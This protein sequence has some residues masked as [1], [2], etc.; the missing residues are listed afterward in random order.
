MDKYRSR[1]ENSV[2]RISL[3]LKILY[4]I[5]FINCSVTLLMI[6]MW[7]T[8]YLGGQCKKDD[9]Q[10]GPEVRITANSHTNLTEDKSEYTMRKRRSYTANVPSSCAVFIRDCKDTIQDSFLLKGQKGDRGYTGVPGVTGSTGQKGSKGDTGA[11]GPIGP[12]GRRGEVGLPGLRGSPGERG[13]PGEP[14]IPGEPGLPGPKGDKG[15]QG[16][17]GFPG[18]DGPA[19]LIG[20]KGAPG[21]RGPPGPYGPVGPTGPP[22]PIGYKGDKGYRGL[23][24]YTGHKGDKGEVGPKGDQGYGYPGVTGPRGPKGDKGECQASS[25][26]MENLKMERDATNRPVRTPQRDKFVETSYGRNVK[27]DTNSDKK[28]SWWAFSM[29]II[30]AIC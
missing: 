23:I 9:F 1:E 15:K 8:S 26:K 16:L 19:G 29:I 10:D 3:H 21:E 28:I 20:E 4:G 18:D 7:Y 22:G 11:I 14:G 2:N 5:L 24:G 17:L 25:F 6:M 13:F 12:R 27:S 30:Y